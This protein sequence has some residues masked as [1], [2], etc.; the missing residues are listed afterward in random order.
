MNLDKL[1]ARMDA[2]EIK[3][4]GEELDERD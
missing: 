3:G 1:A 4:D 2:N